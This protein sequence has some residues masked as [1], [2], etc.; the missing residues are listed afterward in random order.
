M[1]KKIK[2]TNITLDSK[3]NEMKK[4]FKNIQKN[5][6]SQNLKLKKLYK[7][8]TEQESDDNVLLID[9]YLLEQKI[10]KL[11]EDITKIKNKDIEWKYYENS[12]ILLYDYYDSIKTATEKKIIITMII[13][14]LIFLIK[15]IIKILIKIKELIY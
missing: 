9:K 4:K 14:L 1:V 2:S 7:F 6:S 11:E 10:K 3:H 15:I 8:Q 13:I 5:L 12:S